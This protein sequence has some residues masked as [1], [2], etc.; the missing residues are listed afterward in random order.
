MANFV[1]PSCGEETRVFAGTPG[2]EL[3]ETLGTSF[4][5]SIPLDPK[6]GE[7]GDRGV[8]SIIAHPERPQAIAFNEIAGRLAQQV[9]IMAMARSVA[10]LPTGV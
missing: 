2:S 6:V 3:A 7:A 1:C 9:S 8:P 5:G 10:D 4:L